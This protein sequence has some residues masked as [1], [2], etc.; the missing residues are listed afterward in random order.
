MSGFHL[1]YRCFLSV[2]ISAFDTD[3]MVSSVTLWRL[4]FMSS[5]QKIFILCSC[6][7]RELFYIWNSFHVLLILEQVLFF[8]HAENFNS[9]EI[10]I[11]RINKQSFNCISVHKCYT[12]KIHNMPCGNLSWEYFINE[13]FFYLA[14]ISVIGTSQI[15]LVLSMEN[16]LL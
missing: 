10:M 13:I 11:V 14:D 6:V 5:Q 12:L 3:N 1:C 2:R 16:M 8:V 15:V 7:C 4:I 9:K